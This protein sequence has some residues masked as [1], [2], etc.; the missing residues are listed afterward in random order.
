MFVLS[1]SRAV[2][3]L[4]GVVLLWQR[5]ARAGC[6]MAI[7]SNRLT[8]AN[9]NRHAFKLVQIDVEIT[10]GWNCLLISVRNGEDSDSYSRLYQL[11]NDDHQDSHSNVF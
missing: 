9:D 2:G 10:A 1:R 4:Y 6:Q 3:T 11:Q 8:E 7:L 5:V